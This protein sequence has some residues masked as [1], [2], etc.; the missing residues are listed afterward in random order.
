MSSRAL[1]DVASAYA[2]A[3]CWLSGDT[4]GLNLQ[5]DELEDNPVLVLALVRAATS[6]TLAELRT[7][8]AARVDEA[9]D[10]LSVACSQD[11]SM[12]LA[13]AAVERLHHYGE[14]ACDHELQRL[15]A[16]AGPRGAVAAATGVLG[17]AL[18]LHAR[19]EGTGGDGLG[20]AQ[21]RL[22]DLAAQQD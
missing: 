14:V 1:H 15:M 13:A 7:A 4:D 17:Q 3:A 2:L 22:L 18:D 19:L 5:I 20:I 21:R 6:S 8:A 10:T 12:L 16:R 11:P 9:L